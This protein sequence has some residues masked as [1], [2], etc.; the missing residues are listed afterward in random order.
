MSKKYL[1]ML[2]CIAISYKHNA[3]GVNDNSFEKT[4]EKKNHAAYI[5]NFA[6]NLNSKNKWNFIKNS[7]NFILLS[8]GS[9]TL[10]YAG[11]IIKKK[12]DTTKTFNENIISFWEYVKSFFSKK[13]TIEKSSERISAIE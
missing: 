11:M 6:Q 1:L 8:A 12:Y 9:L 4:P 2:L 7:R 5:A 13:T 3:Y 10:M